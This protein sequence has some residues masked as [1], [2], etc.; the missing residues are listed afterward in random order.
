MADVSQHHPLFKGL[1][2]RPYFL[3]GAGIEGGSLRFP[4][5]LHC[6]LLGQNRCE[7]IWLQK[8]LFLKSV[9]FISKSVLIHKI[10]LFF[11]YTCIFRSESKFDTKDLLT[12][13]CHPSWEGDFS[14][15]KQQLTGFSLQRFPTDTFW[16]PRAGQTRKVLDLFLA[17]QEKGRKEWRKSDACPFHWR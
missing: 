17:M 7:N 5:C 8:N 15:L 4:C 2:S 16:Q 6:I 11:C 13:H 9:S 10:Y 14:N 1:I 12:F 3:M